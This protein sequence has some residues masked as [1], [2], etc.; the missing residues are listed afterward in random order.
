MLVLAALPLTE[1]Q[2]ER[3]ALLTLD[4]FDHLAR[5]LAPKQAAR[6]LASL[7]LGRQPEASV[8]MLVLAAPGTFPVL[9]A[10]AALALAL[11]GVVLLTPNLPFGSAGAADAG[12]AVL[13]SGAA[14]TVAED[15]QAGDPLRRLEVIPPETR[16]RVSLPAVFGFASREDGS[17]LES[18]RLF[19]SQGTRLEFDELDRRARNTDGP[20]RPVLVE[21][22]EGELVLLRGSTGRQACLARGGLR[23]CTSSSDGMSALG[24]ACTSSGCTWACLAGGC[25]LSGEN[26]EVTMPARSILPSTAGSPVGLSAAQASFWNDRCGGCFTP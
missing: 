10:V 11:A 24:A 16:V 9:P 14:D 5:G 6:Q 4:D 12:N 17:G 21:A 26:R 7:I 15:G 1:S 18:C 20:V 3:D 22:E 2:G 23:F 25:L 19:A 13:L 8:T